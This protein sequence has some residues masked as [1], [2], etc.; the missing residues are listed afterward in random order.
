[1][2]FDNEGAKEDL[3]I[4]GFNET[5]LLNKIRH[6]KA[7]INTLSADRKTLNDHD[8]GIGTV[9][10]LDT[11]GRPNGNMLKRI[12]VMAHSDEIGRLNFAIDK[13]SPDH[14]KTASEQKDSCVSHLRGELAEMSDEQV[15]AMLKQFQ[16]S[17]GVLETELKLRESTRNMNQE[18]SF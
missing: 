9:S 11:A 1:M 14:Q 4:A 3:G 15:Q 16:K 6:D 18:N 8:V 5:E 10:V 2:R 17:A 13:G 12:K 7:T